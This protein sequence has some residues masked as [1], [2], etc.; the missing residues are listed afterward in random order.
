M[1]DSCFT[2]YKL[3]Y[4]E[5]KNLAIGDVVYSENI[6]AE[7]HL[8]RIH[9]YPCGFRKEDKG[10]YVSLY[11]QLVSNSTNVK[12]IFEA[13]MM[14]KKGEPCRHFQARG[15]HV[16]NSRTPWGSSHKFVM[17]MD[18]ECFYVTNGWATIMWG[19]IVLH[20]DPLAVPPSDIRSH[21]GKLLESAEGSEVSF[22]VDGQTFP[23]H[24][25]VLAARSPVFKAQLLGSMA[26]AKM[27]SVTLHYGKTTHCR[28]NIE[29]ST[30]TVF[31]EC[32][33]EG[34]STNITH[35]VK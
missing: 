34:H 3:N 31:V 25:A 21:F 19:V 6:S 5:M 11:L 1:F 7:G 22:L 17:L 29:H 24:R 26:D 14:D 9:C 32:Q 33:E 20:D 23:A 35:T 30:K 13:F 15:L 10:E 8:W 28:V 18:L 27:S 4:S 16:Y 2:R 12:A